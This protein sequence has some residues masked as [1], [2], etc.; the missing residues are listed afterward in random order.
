M[1]CWCP[2]ACA[3][4]P[5]DFIP[6]TW[7]LGP[8]HG[9][10]CLLAEE[11]EAD[12]P[13]KFWLVSLAGDKHGTIVP[14]PVWHQSGRACTHAPQQGLQI[15]VCRAAATS[16]LQTTEW[17]GLEAPGWCC[18]AASGRCGV[19]CGVR[20][21]PQSP[22]PGC[23]NP[24][25]ACWGCPP[26]M[27]TCRGVS[28]CLSPQQGLW[29]PSGQSGGCHSPSNGQLSSSLL[30]RGP[31]APRASCSCPSQ[32]PFRKAGGGWVTDGSGTGPGSGFSTFM[33]LQHP[34]LF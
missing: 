34:S 31:Q 28:S 17:P 1:L 11:V 21:V 30:G 4:V 9:L 3:E 6:S 26:A 24:I 27:P 22:S 23:T 12:L 7:P 32:S 19:F 13:A 10:L 16:T 8:P 25:P 20:A 33:L 14:V 18:C 29:F 5:Q 2:Q 15:T